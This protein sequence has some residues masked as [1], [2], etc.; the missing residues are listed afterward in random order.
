MFYG[1]SLWQGIHQITE[2]PLFL[3]ICGFLPI[4]SP[5]SFVSSERHTCFTFTGLGTSMRVGSLPRS[6]MWGSC[7]CEYSESWLFSLVRQQQK[8]A[9]VV[10]G[11]FFLP[12]TGFFVVR[13]GY[14]S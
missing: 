10:E 4:S 8:E 5:L 11:H 12:H 7:T 9:R 2:H 6:R 13:E 14:L 1:L 3:T